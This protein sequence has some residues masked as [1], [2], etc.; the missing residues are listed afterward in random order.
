MPRPVRF[1]EDAII[2]ALAAFR[3]YRGRS[4]RAA[5][6]FRDELV[7]AVD[8]IATSP[9]AWPSYVSGTRRYLVRRF[10]FL[11]VFTATP[12]EIQVVAVAHARRRPGYWKD[13]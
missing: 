2:E 8:A 3:W 6:R 9:E 1:S 11:V 13:R 7:H 4:D 5:A 12:D 10:P